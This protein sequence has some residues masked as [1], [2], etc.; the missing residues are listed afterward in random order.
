MTTEPRFTFRALTPEDL[1]LVAAWRRKPH[2]AAWWG[3]P[4]TDEEVRD[5]L[6]PDFGSEVL[7]RF[8]AELDGA[9]VG[10]VQAYDVMRCDPA[11]WRDETDPG[12]RGIDLFLGE[13]ALLGRGLGA[14]MIAAFVRSLFDGDPHV[15]KVQADPSP[16]NVRSIRAFERA[17]FRRVAEIVTPDGP[18]L[19]MVIRRDQR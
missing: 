19:L 15:T 11:W 2:V 14:R 1:P 8:I 13:E 17:G 9:P 16:S 7:W 6:L 4:P 18:A 10:L 12:A 5:D 3:G